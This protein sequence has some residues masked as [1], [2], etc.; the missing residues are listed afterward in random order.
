MIHKTANIYLIL[1]LASLVIA[2]CALIPATTDPGKQTSEIILTSAAGARQSP[3]ENVNFKAG[4]PDG[5]IISIYPDQVKQTIDGIGTSF[6]ESSAF[7]LAHLDPEK[8]KGVMERIYGES[9]ANFS[10]TRT[11]IGAC[12]FSVEGNYSYADV[13]GDTAL[14]SFSLAEDL[15]GFSPEK[16]PGI[17]DRNYDLLPIIQEALSI[18]SAQ[19]DQTLRIIGS[20]WTAPAWMKDI[21]DWYQGMTEENGWNGTGG[22][23]KPEYVETYAD[24]LVRYLDEYKQ[25]GVEL[26]GMTPVNEP[27]GNNGQWESMNFSPESQSEFVQEHLGPG[28]RSG[29]Y[30]DLKLLIFDQNRDGIEEWTDVLYP[31]DKEE[32]YIY[33]VA[34]HWYESTMKVYEDVFERINAKYP[35]YSIVHTEGCIDDLGKPAPAECTDPEGRTEENWFN[36]DEFWWTPSASDWAYAVPWTPGNGEDHPLYTPVHRYARNIIVSLDHWM[37]GWVDWNI[38]LDKQ[39]GPNHVGNFCGAPIMIDTD[40]QDV[41]YTP[42]YDVLSQFSRSI[43]PGD[44]A[45]QTEKAAPGLGADDLHA[46]ATINA[47]NMLSVQLLNTS[48]GPIQYNLQVGEIFAPLT[49]PA[50]S[51]QTVRTQL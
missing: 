26:W 33:G 20:A 19:K 17:K 23:L 29:G 8:R 3:Q 45:V 16:Y 2:G 51:V 21:E 46:C 48:Q 47:D 40:N 9:G 1:I 4:T 27:H 11:H 44:R 7:V 28:L 25:A 30:S 49:I 42:V 35:E 18:K 15:K 39:G 31:A 22:S 10:L 12:D 41:Y 50:N 32:K 5:V 37:T 6:T 13:K 24:Y 34:V 38:V 36:N 14:E 43:R